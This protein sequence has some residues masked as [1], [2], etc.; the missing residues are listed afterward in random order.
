M[1]GS[2][3]LQALISSPAKQFA[4]TSIKKM[5]YKVFMAAFIHA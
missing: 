4:A 3:E 5:V 2:T 1:N